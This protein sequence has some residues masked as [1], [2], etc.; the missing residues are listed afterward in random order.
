[1]SKEQTPTRTA[2][3]KYTD[4]E[5][6]ANYGI[7]GWLQCVLKAQETHDSSRHKRKI[8]KDKK[9]EKKEKKDDK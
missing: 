4:E 8:E 3:E 5:G 6:V 7:W 1:M 2:V 9:H